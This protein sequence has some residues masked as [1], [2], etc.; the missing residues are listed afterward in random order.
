MPLSAARAEGA[1]AH[2][3]ALEAKDP[4]AVQQVKRERNE[5][6]AEGTSRASDQTHRDTRRIGR[7]STERIALTAGRTSTV[8]EVLEQG[9]RLAG[10]SP[11]HP[12]IRGEPAAASVRCSWRGIAR[13]ASQREDAIRF[14][15]G[16]GATDAIPDA[17]YL[18]IL[19]PAVLDSLDRDF[20]ETAKANFLA[21][22]RGGEVGRGGV[23]MCGVAI[24]CGRMIVC[25]PTVPA[26]GAGRA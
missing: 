10:A 3:T 6:R 23:V 15:L 16:L 26:A 2:A 14:W 12:A 24:I 7:R 19:F 11:A 25:G 9:F 1:A 5:P 18:E 8:E 21:I 20:R 13:T 22:A 4:D 17:T